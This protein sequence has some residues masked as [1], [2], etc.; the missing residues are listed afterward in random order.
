MTQT[1]A[2]EEIKIYFFIFSRHVAH[3]LLRSNGHYSLHPAST[4]DGD[5]TLYE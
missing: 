5:S 2:V 1:A 3:I 4:I